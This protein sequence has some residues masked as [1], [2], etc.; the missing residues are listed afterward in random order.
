MQGT[1]AVERFHETNLKRTRA[2]ELCKVNPLR[3]AV[4]EA[5]QLAIVEKDS[6]AL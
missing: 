5:E 3:W 1:W 4:L 6:S 2:V